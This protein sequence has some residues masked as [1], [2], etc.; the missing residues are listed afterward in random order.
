LRAD[1][2]KELPKMV[3]SL[4]DALKPYSQRAQHRRRVS[5]RAG[6]ERV[7]LRGGPTVEK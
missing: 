7:N 5:N 1:K 6:G 4:K 3:Q 2:A